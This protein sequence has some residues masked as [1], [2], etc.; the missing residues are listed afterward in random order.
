MATTPIICALLMA[1]KKHGV[2][3][4]ENGTCSHPLF[5]IAQKLNKGHLNNTADDGRMDGVSHIVNEWTYDLLIQEKPFNFN[6]IDKELSFCLYWIEAHLTGKRLEKIGSPDKK[7]WTTYVSR[8][9]GTT[10]D[11]LNTALNVTEC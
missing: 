5:E 10:F 1:F 2:R 3:L 8:Y 11:A 4:D 7:T 9:T 6:T